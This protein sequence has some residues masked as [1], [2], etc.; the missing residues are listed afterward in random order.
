MGLEFTFWY[1]DVIFIFSN[2]EKN[3]LRNVD[4]KL[5]KK[6]GNL[7]KEI[8]HYLIYPLSVKSIG[9]L[10]DKLKRITIL[11]FPTHQKKSGIF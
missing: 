9:P 3:Y 6:P 4:L 1:L 11:L 10:P 7:F 5:N 8:W 2:T